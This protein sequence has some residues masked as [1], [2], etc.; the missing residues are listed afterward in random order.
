MRPPRWQQK[1]SAARYMVTDLE[2]HFAAEEERDDGDDD[3]G[4]RKN[5][6]IPGRDSMRQFVV[7]GL[8]RAAIQTLP[9]TEK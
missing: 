1:Y 5:Q 9:L 3:T 7:I 8:I 2:D 6:R 4:R